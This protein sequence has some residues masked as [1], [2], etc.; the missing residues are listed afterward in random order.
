VDALLF[1]R[2]LAIGFAI[3]AP[4]GPV[5]I[6]C[7]RKAMADGRVA[8]LVAGLG[9]AVADTTFGAVVGLGLG[10]VSHLLNGHAVVLKSVGGTFLLVLGARTWWQAASAVEPAEGKGPGL[11]RDFVST[12]VITMTNPG[13][14]LGVMGVFAA[15]GAAARPAT[16]AQSWLLV[17][18]VFAGSTL[19]WLV[20]AE[21]TILLRAR[22]T[23]D[24]IRKLN[25]ISGALLV[26]FGIG[27]L[28]SL[29]F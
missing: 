13:T 17:G 28:G 22:F 11:W 2:G 23:A 29:F 16:G 5:G 14:I 9:A 8:A 27:A 18:G 7:I 1:L 21:L 15:F 24:G 20:L 12:F 6:L 4:I 10:T 19:W 25:H 26:V 3:A